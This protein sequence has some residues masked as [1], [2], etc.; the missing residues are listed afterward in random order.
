MKSYIR[1]VSE[2]VAIQMESVIASS[3]PMHNEGT[4]ATPLSNHRGGWSMEDWN[5]EGVEE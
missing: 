3:V 4:D 5:D 1:P 2:T